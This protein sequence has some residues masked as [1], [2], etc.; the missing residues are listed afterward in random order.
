MNPGRFR[1]RLRIMRPIKSKDD[2]GGDSPTWVL[3]AVV[4]AQQ[5]AG[6]GREFE[7]IMQR[8]AD[9]K[10]MFWTHYVSGVEREFQIQWL[11]EQRTLTLDILDVRVPAGVRNCLQIIARDAKAR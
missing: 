10:Y 11:T 8:F 7:A 5:L 3:F 4:K 1:N 2:I 9:A 6:Q